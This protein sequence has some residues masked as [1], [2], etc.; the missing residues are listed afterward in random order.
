MNKKFLA[1][2]GSIVS[3]LLLVGAGCV[4]D[5][6]NTNTNTTTNTVK[7]NTTKTTNK[8]KTNTNKTTTVD[9]D[10]PTIEIVSPVDGA[11]VATTFDLEV[12][13]EG[14]TLAPDKV[15]GVNAEGEGHY[16]VWVDGE[17]FAP[18]MAETTTLEDV[19]VG[20]HEV[21]VSLQNNDHS[22]LDNAVKSESVTVTVE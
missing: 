8:A 17:Y 12:A 5:T 1:V 20:E 2:T 3:A 10:T 7:T 19:A 21:M 9:V 15:E 18:G 13:V 6:T 11:T 14:F 4:T 16:H 22:D